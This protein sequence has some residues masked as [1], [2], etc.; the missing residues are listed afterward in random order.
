M[1][2]IDSK[3]GLESCGLQLCCSFYGVSPIMKIE[4]DVLSLTYF[5][6]VGYVLVQFF[7]VLR[8]RYIAMC[9]MKLCHAGHSHL[10]C[11][12]LQLESALKPQGLS[13]CLFQAFWRALDFLDLSVR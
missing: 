8:C 7:P 13:D 12:R 6:G 1:C 10:A 3:D 5:S 4:N 2:G 11:S 9:Y